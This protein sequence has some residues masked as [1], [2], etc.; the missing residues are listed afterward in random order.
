MVQQLGD[1]AGTF[2]A[3][4]NKFRHSHVSIKLYSLASDKPEL[5]KDQM[6]NTF[7]SFMRIMIFRERTIAAGEYLVEVSIVWNEQA[8]YD[9]CHKDAVVDLICKDD[10]AFE[11]LSKRDSLELLKNSW[12]NPFFSTTWD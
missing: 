2:K 11:A 6:E 1:I 9:Q 12:E 4:H 7:S 3:E 8:N 5:I 10:V